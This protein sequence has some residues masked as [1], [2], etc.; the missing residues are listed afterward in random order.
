VRIKFTI[1]FL[2]NNVAIV[3]KVPPLSSV[4]FA[5]KVSAYSENPPASEAGCRVV[6]AFNNPKIGENNMSAAAK[7]KGLANFS[8]PLL[9]VFDIPTKRLCA[10][11]VPKQPKAQYLDQWRKLN[12]R[13]H[14]LLSFTLFEIYLGSISSTGL[15][16]F[17]A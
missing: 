15:K 9:Y 10:K 4:G 11:F 1:Q 12:H 6:A 2:H 13:P 5:V 16:N 3:Q 8:A 7:I 14:I 17:R